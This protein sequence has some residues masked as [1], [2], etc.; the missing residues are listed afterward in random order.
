MAL[1]REFRQVGKPAELVDALGK[2]WGQ[3]KLVEQRMRWARN[4]FIAF[5][6]LMFISFFIGAATGHAWL[7]GLMILGV[8]VS[9]ILW[10]VYHGYNLDDRRI[11]TPLKLLEVLQADIP[12][13]TPVRVMV[14]FADYR[15]H[16][17]K[18]EEDKSFWKGTG[19]SK[20]EDTWLELEGWLAEK[21]RFR[22]TLTQRVSR[23][24]KRKRKYTKCRERLRESVTLQLR[25]NPKL[26]TALDRFPA[27]FA[28]G[29]PVPSLRV[30]SVR[31]AGRGVLVVAE[32]GTYTKLSGRATSEI[33]TE[34]LI[35][36]QKLLMLMVAVFERLNR[37]RA[38][39][40]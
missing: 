29:I 27:Q 39:A 6:I 22:L 14:S 30:E 25:P 23:A 32:G 38:A 9:G 18:L 31:V 2:L 12:P 40:A 3:D 20:F 19:R 28:T 10:A 36:G 24:E 13:Q 5:I 33:G 26:Y 11:L 16:G 1:V 4:S 34:N 35:D 7:A 17:R 8:V 15:K 37:C 21:T